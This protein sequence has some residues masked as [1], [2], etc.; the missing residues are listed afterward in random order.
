MNDKFRAMYQ[1]TQLLHPNGNRIQW[2]YPIK[3]FQS[4]ITTFTIQMWNR[5]ARLWVIA[6]AT[7]FWN[8]SFCHLQSC[9]MEH[10]HFHLAYCQKCYRYS[11]EASY[12]WKVKC[13]FSCIIYLSFRSNRYTNFRA[14]VYYTIPKARMYDLNTND[15][16]KKK[17]NFCQVTWERAN[18]EVTERESKNEGDR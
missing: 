11:L 4:I 7:Q 17:H 3:W 6:R 14:F 8:E 1:G 13:W 16:L 5:L 12:V 15:E 9:N 10:F 18:G 2:L